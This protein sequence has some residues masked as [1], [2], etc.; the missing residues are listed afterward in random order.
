MPVSGRQWKLDCKRSSSMRVANKLIRKSW[1]EKMKERAR[2]K[3]IK[4]KQDALVQARIDEKREKKRLAEERQKRKEEN[5]L[6]GAVVQSISTMKV[7]KMSRKQL[8]MIRKMDTSN[9]GKVFDLKP[10]EKTKGLKGK[11]K[12]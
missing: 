4:A 2:D 12:I 6:K 3:Q 5:R 9:E 11:V 7:K 1:D 8:R 10:I